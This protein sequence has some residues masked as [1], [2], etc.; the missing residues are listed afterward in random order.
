MYSQRWLSCA[1]LTSRLLSAR[2]LY[3]HFVGAA[4]FV[5]DDVEKLLAYIDAQGQ[6]TSE[7]RDSNENAKR[8]ERFADEL[9][10]WLVFSSERLSCGSA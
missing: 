4:I 5:S 3:V 10:L 2:V 8:G 6:Q 1:D 7:G 9:L